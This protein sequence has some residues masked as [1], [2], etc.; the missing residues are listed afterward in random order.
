MQKIDVNGRI[1]IPK[2]MRERLGITSDTIVDVFERGNSI[3]LKPRK[4]TYEITQNQLDV[5][6]Q[7]YEV[8]KNF[9]MIDDTSLNVFREACYISDMK[10]PECGSNLYVTSDKV[11]VCPKC[12]M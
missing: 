9:N 3:V 5:L 8:V 7:V 1:G 2:V 11:S 6:R 4:E 10:C 12:D